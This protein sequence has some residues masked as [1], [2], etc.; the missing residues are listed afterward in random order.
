MSIVPCLRHS[1]SNKGIPLKSEFIE[2]GTVRQTDRHFDYR[3][4]LGCSDID[5]V[6]VN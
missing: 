4:P 1:T 3:D 2:N 6:N 5:A